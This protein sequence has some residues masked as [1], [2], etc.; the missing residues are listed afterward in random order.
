M[1]ELLATVDPFAAVLTGLWMFSA[2]LFPLGFMLGSQCSPC[3]GCSA[4]TQG[5][6]PETLTVTFSGLADKTPGPDLI[7]VTFSSC[8]GSG[9]TAKVTAPSGDPATDKGPITAVSLT[10]GGGGYAKLGRVAPTLTVSGGSGTGAT[11]TPTLST[12]QDGCK[13][14]LWSLASVAAS[15]GTGYEDGDTLTI[16]FA[17]GDTEAAAAQATLYLGKSE[18]TITLNG[19]ATAT[20]GLGV[21][22]TPTWVVNDV[23]VTNGGTGYTEGGAVT[24]S[25]GANDV[26]VTAAAGNA[27][28]VHDAPENAVLTIATAGGSGAVLTP[29]W[30]LLPSGQWPAPHK[31]TYK[32]QSVTVVNGGTGYANYEPIS[33]SFPSAD[34]GTVNQ[35][36]YIDCDVVGAGGVIQSIFIADPGD[37][38]TPAAAGRYVGSRTDA[39]H[40][41]EITNAGEYY[42]DNPG[43]RYVVVD[44]GGSYYREDPDEPPYV[45]TVTVT[46]TDTAPSS[47][48][49]AALSVTVDDDTA[50]PT[51]GQLIGVVTVTNGGAG[52]LAWQWR[53]TQCCGGYYNGMSVVVKLNNH[54][55]GSFSQQEPCRFIHRMCGVG[56]RDTNLGYVMVEY[57]G[58]NTPPVVYLVSESP[59]ARNGTVSSDAEPSGI[60]NT[61][62]TTAQLVANCGTWL[63]EAG[64]PLQFMATGGAAAT[65]V[66]G[67]VY[68]SAFKDSGGA[69]CHI[70]C[71]GAAAVPNEI[72]ATFSDTRPTKTTD[73]SG[74]YVMPLLSASEA[75][76]V[77]STSALAGIG[78]NIS[79]T[80]CATQPYPPPYAFAPDGSG[81]DD[82]H[83]KCRV[84][85]EVNIF[86]APYACGFNTLDLDD[87][88]GQCEA[89]PVCAPAGRSFSGACGTLTVEAP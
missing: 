56:N 26:T 41:V 9:A 64:Q 84:T 55:L 77:W 34:D 70:C 30:T 4:C 76:M 54:A 6:L 12:S 51:F 17:D 88:C 46:V 80:P 2:G 89:T 21:T 35:A 13:L 63:D 27:R 82:C 50:S 44:N 7:S 48:S 42:E 85:A 37:I 62:F 52:Y 33:I 60:C 53:N 72:S 78:I 45:A 65:V 57:L 28:V 39:L 59:L 83:N 22:L 14:D 32:L 15:G 25:A 49:G 67:G 40:S 5:Q 73:L 38:F 11:F 69:S 1:L 24:F 71:K 81:C 36:A 87:P 66:F 61:T 47:G 20:I 75:A 43:A 31:K 68:D 74:T 29:V 23:T 16:T 8:Y 19:T 10:N 86:D 58:P 18:P 79:F 3:C